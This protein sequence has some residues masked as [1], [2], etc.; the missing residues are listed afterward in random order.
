MG[1]SKVRV[2][3]TFNNACSLCRKA[4]R[5]QIKYCFLGFADFF[6]V[7]LLVGYDFG[8]PILFLLKNLLVQELLSSGMWLD[9]WSDRNLL[10]DATFRRAVPFT[11]ITCICLL[12]KNE[13]DVKLILSDMDWMLRIVAMFCNWGRLIL[14]VACK[15]VRDLIFL[16]NCTG[17]AFL[18]R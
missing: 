7:Y 15:S 10:H 9:L 4:F 6:A 1:A 17:L 12:R 18:V 11:G 13:F 14:Y 8:C 16:P 5:M 2:N 3:T